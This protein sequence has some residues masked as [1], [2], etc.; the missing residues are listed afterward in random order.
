MC[1]VCV[2]YVVQEGTNGILRVVRYEDR[3]RL[4]VYDS[5]IVQS[6]EAY[7][8]GVEDFFYKTV[9]TPTCHV[10]TVHST[11]NSRHY[12]YCSVSTRVPG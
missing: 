10:F 7:T 9:D 2:W 5:Y 4:Q 11:C 6:Q 1:V 8:E 12:Y 3:P